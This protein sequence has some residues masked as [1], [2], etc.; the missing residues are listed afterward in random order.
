MSLFNLSQVTSF[1]DERPS[2]AVQTQQIDGRLTARFAVHLALILNGLHGKQQQELEA[3]AER[4]CSFPMFGLLAL[5][6]TKNTQ[7]YL[8][9]TVIMLA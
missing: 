6:R 8:Y 9:G 5:W 2:L 3:Q 1:V 7:Q 4:G